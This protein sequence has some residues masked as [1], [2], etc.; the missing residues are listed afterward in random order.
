MKIADYNERPQRFVRNSQGTYRFASYWIGWDAN[1]NERF[2]KPGPCISDHVVLHGT[3]ATQWEQSFIY[4]E[5]LYPKF[6]ENMIIENNDEDDGPPDHRVC[7]RSKA[8]IRN[9]YMEGWFNPENDDPRDHDGRMIYSLQTLSRL[10][11][12]IDDPT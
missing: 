10:R 4:G 8:N 12:A 1:K 3:L 2:Q 7:W 9:T 5:N 6:N 11:K